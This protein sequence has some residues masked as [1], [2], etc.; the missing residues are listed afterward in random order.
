M[1][2]DNADPMLFYLN[3]VALPEKAFSLF[4]AR[5]LIITT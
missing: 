2:Y 5:F 3:L 4:A 1:I